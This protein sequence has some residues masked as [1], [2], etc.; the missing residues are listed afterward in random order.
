MVEFV[1]TDTLQYN[2]NEKSLDLMGS[3]CLGTDDIEEGLLGQT[4]PGSQPLWYPSKVSIL[5]Q[6]MGKSFI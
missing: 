5:H 6:I 3:D 2:F 4:Y 1:G